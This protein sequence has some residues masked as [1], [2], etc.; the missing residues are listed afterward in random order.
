M[1]EQDLSA[2]VRDLEARLAEREAQL[3]AARALAAD[4]ERSKASFLA[5]MSHELRT[6]LSRILGNCD[7]LEED[8]QDAGLTDSAEEV[9]RIRAAARHLQALVDDVLDLAA[10]EVGEVMVDLED[11]D[12]RT[13]T[14][15]VVAQIRP[16]AECRSNRVIVQLPPQLP[17]L[18]SDG[19]KV[20]QCLW[21]LLSNAAKFTECGQI[22]LTVEPQ[23][24]AGRP[25]MVFLVD[26]TGIGMTPEEIARL[27]VPF[28]QADTSVTRE[29]GGTGLGMAL[30]RR[31]V[32]V[33]NGFIH[34]ESRP[35]VGTTF[36]MWLP[37]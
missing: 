19:R 26:D 7:L 6:P 28:I 27:W 2:R 3:A 30:T 35:G 23:S 25:G 4:A 33:L 34:A 17:T 16:S 29:H 22:T 14:A 36:R 1:A 32:E 21:N 31:L 10:F 20:G 37:G 9:G 18:R 13:L 24:R 15:E 11:L 12:L 5:N 8:I